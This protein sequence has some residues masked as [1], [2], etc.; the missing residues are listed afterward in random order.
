[1]TAAAPPL[2]AARRVSAVAA[3]L[4]RRQPR[5]AY[6]GGGCLALAAVAFAGAVVDPRQ[7]GGVPLW[8]KPA[9]FFVSVGIFALTAAWFFGL[10]RPERRGAR[11][12]RATVATL[13]GAGS[14]ELAYIVLQ[15]ARGE[16]SHFN[17]ADPLH[18]ILYALMGVG[19]VLLVGT[20]LPLAWEIARRPAPGADPAYRRAVVLGLVMTVA[21]GGV[22]GGYMSSQAGHAVGAEA[23]HLPL[24]GWNRAGGD[25][26]VAHM[27]GMHAEQALP[28]AAALA[29]ALRLP[30]RRALGWL[31]AAAWALLTLGAFAQAVAGRPFPLG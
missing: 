29:G 12:M 10:V 17:T 19:A 13:V 2:P 31:A 30:R 6:F 20:N 18:A 22:L 24:V 27:L 14:F 5:L 7:F 11:A 8:L 3:E 9:K 21:L 26:R 4:H 28:L 15:A 25:L 1:M 23:G 16:G